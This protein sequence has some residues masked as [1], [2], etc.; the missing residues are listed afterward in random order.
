MP[1]HQVDDGAT[2]Y[3]LRKDAST[4]AI[5]SDGDPV[6][7]CESIIKQGR[8][9]VRARSTVMVRNFLDVPMRVALRSKENPRGANA[10]LWERTV[11]PGELAPVPVHC[12]T[13]NVGTSLSFY[14]EAD[15]K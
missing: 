12:T 13:S 2:R 8:F 9:T 1:G 3:T 5:S 4:R 7:V 10:T 15:N 14:F 6:V 11:E